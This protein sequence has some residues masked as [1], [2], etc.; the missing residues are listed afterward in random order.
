MA[1]AVAEHTC[2]SICPGASPPWSLLGHTASVPDANHST[3]RF[4][5]PDAVHVFGAGLAR[6]SGTTLRSSALQ[7]PGLSRAVGSSLL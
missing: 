3:A 5:I 6:L 7:R 4:Q 1:H 2:I